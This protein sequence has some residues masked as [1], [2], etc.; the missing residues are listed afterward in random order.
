[1]KCPV[2]LEQISAELEQHLEQDPKP[3]H[4][5]GKTTKTIKHPSGCLILKRLVMSLVFR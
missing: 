2:W 5:N 3:S 1:M 4:K